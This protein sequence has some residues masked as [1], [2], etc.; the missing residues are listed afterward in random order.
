MSSGLWRS[1]QFSLARVMISQSKGVPITV[2][3]TSQ[4]KNLLPADFVRPHTN[5]IT[6]SQPF[7]SIETGLLRKFRTIK[8][9]T[10]YIEMYSVSLLVSE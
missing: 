10:T 8:S 5:Q 7:E 4:C 6:A 9:T 1:S 2:R 3:K